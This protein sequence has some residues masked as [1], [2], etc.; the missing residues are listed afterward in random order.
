M[1]RSS[2][3][4][5][6]LGADHRGFE[7]KEK[8]KVWLQDKGYQ[9]VDCGNDHYDPDDDFPDFAFK[10]AQAVTQENSGQALGIVLCGSGAGVTI[11]ANKV[12]FARA[13]NGMH[14]EEVRHARLH[15]DLNV[16]ALATDYLDIDQIKNLSEIFLT[17]EFMTK[18]RYQRRLQKIASYEE[19]Q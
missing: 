17:T 9:V 18:D 1:P 7:T 12:K 4:S 16:L 15:N 13:A 3:P 14:P 19:K 11:A 2:N 5:V 6:Y 8:L 10:V